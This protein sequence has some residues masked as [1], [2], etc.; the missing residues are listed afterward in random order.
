MSVRQDTLL[1]L[2]SGHIHLFPKPQT[3]EVVIKCLLCL[4]LSITA[5]NIDDMDGSRE[6]ESAPAIVE[7]TT[8]PVGPPQ[9]PDTPTV[10]RIT[11]TSATVSWTDPG[12]GVIYSFCIDSG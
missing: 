8:L 12:N 4:R 2:K 3:R 10:S 7:V 11:N 1:S 9:V 6:R 5:F